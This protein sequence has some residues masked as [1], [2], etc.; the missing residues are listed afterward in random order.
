MW[1]AAIGD[2]RLPSTAQSKTVAIT[3]GNRTASGDHSVRNPTVIT[4]QV[5]WWRSLVGTARNAA[6][7]SVRN[8]TVITVCSTRRRIGRNFA[9]HRNS[10]I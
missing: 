5:P 4:N 1:R 3:G 10:R 2:R 6:D 7:Q 8:P 9:C